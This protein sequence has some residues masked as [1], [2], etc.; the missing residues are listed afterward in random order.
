MYRRW[1]YMIIAIIA[2]AI[3]PSQKMF[4]FQDDKGIIYVRSFSMDEKVF[5]VTQTELATGAEEVT[6]T[7]SIA[8]LYYCAKAML[9]LCVL[10]F[11]CFFSKR[12]RMVLAVLAAIL[13]GAYYILMIYYAVRITDEHFTTLYPT[14]MAVLPAIVLQLML[15]VRRNVAHAAMLENINEE[16]DE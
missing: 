3:L 10:C 9:V 13:A 5:Y 12:G 4:S 14:I 15:L 6:E 8:G 11:F 7:M 2:S 1:I 16:K